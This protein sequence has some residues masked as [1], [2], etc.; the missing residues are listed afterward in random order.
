M[1]MTL[2]GLD[3]EI[4]DWDE[5]KILEDAIKVIKYLSTKSTCLLEDFRNR[6]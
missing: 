4:Q 1:L 2:K 6:N 3:L 5:Y